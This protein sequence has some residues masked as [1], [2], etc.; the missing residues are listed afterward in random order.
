MIKDKIYDIIVSPIYSEKSTANTQF[1]KYTF[2]VLKSA[3][4]AQ[5]KSVFKKLFDVEA[6]E[7]NILNSKPKT[8]VFKGMKGVRQ[9]YKKAIV[10]VE[11]GK[12]L[13]FMAGA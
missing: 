11:K 10:T 7:V 1:S 6:V 9:G 5:I 4:K 3:N 8:K 2:K 12:T 13:E